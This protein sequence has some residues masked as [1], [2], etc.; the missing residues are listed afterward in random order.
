[1]KTDLYVEL[2]GKQTDS[3]ILIDMAKEA[4]KNSGKK[5]K[6]LNTLELF[7]KPDESKCFYVMN[8]DFKGSFDV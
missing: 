1:M 3:K 2:N 5:V 6:D 8:A 4:W 7:F